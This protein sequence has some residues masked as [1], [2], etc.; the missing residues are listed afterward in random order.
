MTVRIE[1]QHLRQVAAYRRP[2]S[3]ARR[4]NNDNNMGAS[5][6]ET[7]IGVAT[8]ATQ[9]ASGNWLS[10]IATALAMFGGDSKAGYKAADEAS[11]KVIGVYGTDFITGSQAM[12]VAPAQVAQAL[13]D[14]LRDEKK[15]T[16]SADQLLADASKS[17][18]SP[19]VGV[20]SSSNL[21]LY[22]AGGAGA[23]LL[24]L[25]MRR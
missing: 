21:P 17:A 19:A 5:T 10:A 8:V 12:Q 9:V 18:S 14:Y 25:L 4:G 22:I 1:A 6:T 11:K 15:I 7:V 2:S 23:I 16:L 13:S 3:V 24:L 20:L